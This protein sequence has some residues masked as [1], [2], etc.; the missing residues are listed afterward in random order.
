MNMMY[1]FAPLANINTLDDHTGFYVIAACVVGFWL[2]VLISCRDDLD[3]LGW[4]TSIML[5][6]LGLI[7][8]ISWNC[9]EVKYYENKQV[10]GEFVEF[11]AE[12]F[13]ITEYHGKFTRQVDKHFTYVVYKINGENIML[14]ATIGVTYPQTA[15]LY[16]N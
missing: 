14:P 1:T 11:V 9:G 8:L 6:F 3:G 13:N 7:A 4:G 10:Q 15:I 16:K 5:V 2:Y 12:G